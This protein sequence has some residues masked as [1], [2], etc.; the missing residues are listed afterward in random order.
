MKEF[1]PYIVSIVT[2]L[3]AAFS[4]IV[5]SRKG[6]KAE[7]NKLIKQHE[8]DLET[9]REKHS[10]ELEKQRIEH[11]NQIERMQRDAENK[12]GADLVNALVTGVINTPE[13]RNKISQS[14]K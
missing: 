5:I 13:F 2:A 3:I 14:M 4:S 7:I 1:M 6:T 10:Y 12:M 8:L 11:E 9:E